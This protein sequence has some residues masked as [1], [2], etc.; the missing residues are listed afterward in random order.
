M[1]NKKINNCL[2]SSYI[3]RYTLTD[4]TE[5]GLKVIELCNENLRVL[6]N[7][8]KALDIMQVWHKGVNVSFISKNGFTAREI[9]FLNRFEGGMLYTCGIDSM[10]RQEGYELHGYFHNTPAKVISVLQ[11]DDKLQVKA[12]MHCSSLF[13]E[14]LSFERTFTLKNDTFSLEDKLINNGTKAE[15][16]CLLYHTNFGYPMLDEGTEIIADIDK[17]FPVDENA[18]KLLANRTVFRAPIDNEPEKCYYLENN[19]NFVSVVNKKLGKK[20]TVTYSKETLPVLVQWNSD[21]SQD[22]ALGIEPSTSRLGNELTYKHI[23]PNQ[24]INFSISL[25]FKEI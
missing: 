21:A 23:E 13:G 19:Q 5:N 6:L 22:Y 18:E 2:Q 9:P 10:G 15:K 1:D 12:V 16:Y 8:S 14:N 25:D 20:V 17:V 24:T 4:G 7:E 11:E 3:R